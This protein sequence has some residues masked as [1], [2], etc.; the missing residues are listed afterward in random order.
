MSGD[1]DKDNLERIGQ[2][3][4]RAWRQVKTAQARSWGQWMTIGEGLHEGRRWAMHVAG[5]NKPEGKGYVIAFA[6]WLKRFKVDDMDPSD[7]AKLLQLMEERPAVEEWRAT[8]TDHERRNLNNPT[9]TWR[10]WNAATKV[11]KPKPPTANVSGA[12]H[13]RAQRTVEHLQA[14]VEELEQELAGARGSGGSRPD[15]A[16][17]DV[18]PLLRDLSWRVMN[19]QQY[20]VDEMVAGIAKRLIE[21]GPPGGDDDETLGMARSHLDVTFDLLSDV[22]ER[23]DARAK[24]RAKRK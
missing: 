11:K 24:R 8:L 21:L 1:K 13:G 15:L 22:I 12:E 10:K 16:T 5:V 20:G 17:C 2:A 4:M 7:R 18:M 9:S 3:M 14:R 6:E 19:E 23:L